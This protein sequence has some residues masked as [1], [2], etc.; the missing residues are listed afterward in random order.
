MLFNLLN[1]TRKKS[2]K[3]ELWS[4]IGSYISNELKGG[5]C[6]V[7]SAELSPDGKNLAVTLEVKTWIGLKTRHAGLVYSFQDNATVGRIVIGKRVDK[8]WIQS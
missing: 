4:T 8:G 2:D 7:Q 6:N 5:K 3:S 1:G